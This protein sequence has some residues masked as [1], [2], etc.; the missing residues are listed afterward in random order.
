MGY[1][2]GST[3][4]QHVLSLSPKDAGQLGDRLLGEAGGPAAQAPPG[5]APAVD[6]AFLCR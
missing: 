3:G 1:V 5:L 2:R 4:L 6:T